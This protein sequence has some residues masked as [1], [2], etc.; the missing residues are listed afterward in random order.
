MKG[1]EISTQEKKGKKVHSQRSTVA[2]SEELPEW[3]RRVFFFFFSL[4]YSELSDIMS[5][6]SPQ[7]VRYNEGLL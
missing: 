4:G 3:R 5:G 1:I 2:R 6:P 7:S